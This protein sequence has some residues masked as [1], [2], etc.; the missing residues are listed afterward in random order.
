MENGRDTFSSPGYPSDRQ[1]LADDLALHF[2]AEGDGPI[3]PILRPQLDSIARDIKPFDGGLASDDRHDDVAALGDGLQADDDDVAVP[4][5]RVH[6]A[7]PRYPQCAAAPPPREAGLDQDLAQDVFFGQH[8]PASGHH[9]HKRKRHKLAEFILRLPDHGQSARFARLMSEVALFRQVAEMLVDR[10]RPDSEKLGQLLHGGRELPPSDELGYRFQH[11]P[12]CRREGVCRRASRTLADHIPT[13]WQSPA[14]AQPREWIPNMDSGNPNSIRK[15]RSRTR[16]TPRLDIMRLPA[17][18][19][20]GLVP[21]ARATRTAPPR[22]WR[23]RQAGRAAG[24]SRH[25]GL[26]AGS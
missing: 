25:L 20:V 6:H 16:G 8:R 12:L 10:G 26:R 9:A 24:F 3:P 14:R 19:C 2:W 17:R 5:A 18:G 22:R 7:G 4:N 11:P 21:D 13:P 1:H 15:N 23:P